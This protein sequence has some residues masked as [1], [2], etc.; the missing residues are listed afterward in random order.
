VC[1]VVLGQL[2]LV[3]FGSTF[4]G[5][6]AMEWR[7]RRSEWC[8]RQTDVKW[9]QKVDAVGEVGLPQSLSPSGPYAVLSYGEDPRVVL[10]HYIR[11][12]SSML[13]H[14]MAPQQSWGLLRGRFICMHGI[15]ALVVHV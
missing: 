10:F 5:A 2:D 9:M 4:T 12:D 13:V 7:R 15:N 1:G 11:S 3:A 14:F 6:A 8:G